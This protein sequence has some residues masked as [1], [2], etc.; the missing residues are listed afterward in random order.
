MLEPLAQ[1]LYLFLKLQVFLLHKLRPLQLLL[2]PLLLLGRQVGLVEHLLP[3]AYQLGLQ[4]GNLVHVVLDH[5]LLLVLDV[6][7]DYFLNAVGQVALRYLVLLHCIGDVIINHL[8]VHL[9]NLILH[10]SRPFLISYLYLFELVIE[11]LTRISNIA[12]DYIVVGV[13]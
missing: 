12:A 3:E 11:I 2:Q 10:M 8:V 1:V 7:L 6:R 4:E 9:F 13:C 5:L